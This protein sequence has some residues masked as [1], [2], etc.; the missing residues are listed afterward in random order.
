MS[1]RELGTQLSVSWSGWSAAS[2]GLGGCLT[3]GS[4]ILKLNASPTSLQTVRKVVCTLADDSKTADTLRLLELAALGIEAAAHAEPV[5]AQSS[6][7]CGT[8]QVASAQPGSDSAR[9]GVRSHTLKA[10]AKRRLQ[11]VPSLRSICL[12][13]LGPFVNEVASMD[14][15]LLPSADKAV[16]LA[17][18]RCVRSARLPWPPS[19]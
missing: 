14:G 5:T 11:P 19:A 6:A 7:A 4:L 2:I 3:R 18:A 8:P 15:L 17:I 12:G 16:L 1:S 10:S 9:T 13:F